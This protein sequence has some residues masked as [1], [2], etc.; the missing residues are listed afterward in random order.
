MVLSGG[1]FSM[2]P[3]AAASLAIADAV[4]HPGAFTILHD[5][6]RLLAPLGA[7]PLE[8]DRRRLLADLMDDALLPVGSALLTGSNGRE[9][10]VPG[11]LAISSVLGEEEMPLES[12][13][14]RLVDLPPG[15]VARLDVDPGQGTI[16]GVEGRR[17]RLEVSGGLGGLLIDTRPIPLRWPSGA[18]QRRATLAAWEAGAW[19]GT[20]R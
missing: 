19:L 17:L 10:T 12:D 16:L 14:L 9:G 13:Q 5:H 4:R 7:L 11:S 8:A 15:I 20:E 2:V 1:G 3:P 18:E 6:V